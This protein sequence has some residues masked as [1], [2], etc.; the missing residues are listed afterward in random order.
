M[1]NDCAGESPAWSTVGENVEL[2]D[3]RG[4]DGSSFDAFER[5]NLAGDSSYA[6][7]MQALSSRLHEQY[8]GPLLRRAS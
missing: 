3:H 1:L 5:E 6:G 8:P 2:Y 7:I 4:D